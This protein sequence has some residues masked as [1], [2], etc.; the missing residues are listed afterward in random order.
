MPTLRGL[1]YRGAYEHSGSVASL[2]DWF[3]PRRL[4]PDYRPTAWRGLGVERR[5]VPGHEF[6]LDLVDADRGDLIAFLLTL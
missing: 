6:G 5:P 3:D 1:W 4:Q 2:E